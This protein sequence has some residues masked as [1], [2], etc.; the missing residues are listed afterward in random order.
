MGDRPVARCE[1]LLVSPPDSTREVATE[2]FLYH[3]Y[4]GS[5]LLQDNRILEAKEELEQALTMQ[6]ADAKG[7]DLLGAVYF[8]LGLYPRAIQIYEGLERQFPGDVSIKINLALCYLKTGQPEPARRVLRDVVRINPEHRRAWGYLGLA[9]Q[10]LGE[11][12]QAQIAFEKGG[13]GAMARKVTEFRRSLAPVPPDSSPPVMEQGVR[14]MADAAFSELD[15]G[16]LQFALAEAGAPTQGEGHWH[17]VELGGTTKSKTPPRSPFTKTL[18]PPWMGE[19]EPQP[20]LGSLPA[21]SISFSA[22][23]V[24]NISRIV[25]A[26]SVAAAVDEGQADGP[27]TALAEDRELVLVPPLLPSAAAPAVSWHPSG[28]VLVQTAEA[29]GQAF[30]ARLDALRV[31]AGSVSTRV[32]HRRTRDAETRE[33]LGGLGSPFVRVAGDAQV[34]LGARPRQRLVL[35]AVEEELAFVREDLLVG[36]ELALQYE[37]GRVPLEPGSAE[38]SAM[39]QFRGS[40]TFVVDVPGELASL[41]SGSGRPLIARREWIVGWF[42]RLVTRAL[43]STE[44]PGGHRGLTGF[45]GEGTVLVCMG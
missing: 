45:W 24:P 4:R 16:E 21:P 22:P 3:L 25:E 26:L 11:L 35:L 7:Q 19:L 31:V 29:T 32:M 41:P 2:D 20:D 12:E 10:K 18:P 37:N 8:R 36:F 14:D 30:A 13:R 39:V 44:S 43:S 33:V 5:E 17:T 9:L 40:G 27:S 38:E 34:V 23:P 28:V 15:T 1:A 6:P 42:G